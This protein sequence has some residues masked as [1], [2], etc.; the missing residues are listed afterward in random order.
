MFVSLF[1]LL[2]LFVFKALPRLYRKIYSD[3]L[4]Y[5]T[6]EVTRGKADTHL[7]VHTHRTHTH[8]RVQEANKGKG[9]T[10][11]AETCNKV[12]AGLGLTLVTM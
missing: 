4:K 8:T 1:C 12:V 7:C 2:F 3:S 5:L 10:N 11:K 9:K 6:L